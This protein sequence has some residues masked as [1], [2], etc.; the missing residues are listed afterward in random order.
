LWLA[1]GFGLGYSP[2]L[3][4]T[5]GAVWGLPL[6]WLILRLSRWE[7]ALAMLALLGLGIPLCNLA[8]R[9]LAKP[10]PSEVVY[11]EIVSVPLVFLSLA[12]SEP[13]S[14]WA[15]AAGFVWLRVFDIAK[16]P[17]VRWLEQLPGGWGIMADD[18]AAA[19]LAG[20]VLRVT[21]AVWA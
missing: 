17:P 20:L 1:T 15:W 21:L 10:D 12:P 8:R 3:P 11:D 4:G 16:P 14:G 13:A 19:I 2:I 9:L 7:Q 5:C 18:L 6:T